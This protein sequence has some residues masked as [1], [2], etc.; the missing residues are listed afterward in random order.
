MGLIEYNHIQHRE[1]RLV[2]ITAKGQVCAEK[3]VIDDN[4]VGRP[5]RIA[6]LGHIAVCDLRAAIS[7]TVLTGGGHPRHNRRVFR[8]VWAV[9]E[10][11]LG[12]LG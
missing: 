4:Q 1:Q 5:G 6:C 2:R 12:R 3:M 11:A 10:I 8:K 7:E 9:R